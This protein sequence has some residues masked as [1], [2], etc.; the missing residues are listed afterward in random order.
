MPELDLKKV[1][2]IARAEGIPP[3]EVV[4]CYEGLGD[5]D[6]ESLDDHGV[7]IS[8]RPPL[9]LA[10]FDD[11]WTFRFPDQAKEVRTLGAY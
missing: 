11:D 7:L 1:A 10:C 5:A 4:I 9:T 2:D 8:H 3:R 6:V